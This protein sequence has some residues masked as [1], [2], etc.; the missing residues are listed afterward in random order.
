MSHT[1]FTLSS[2]NFRRVILNAAIALSLTATSAQAVTH[3]V[4]CEANLV[5]TNHAISEAL[6]SEREARKA[7]AVL[8]SGGGCAVLSIFLLGLDLGTTSLACTVVMMGTYGALS[9]AEAATISR[10]VFYA[11]RDPRCIKK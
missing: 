6:H 5:A 7:A 9:S 3:R 11:V 1:L 8:A 4:N 2:P 10:N